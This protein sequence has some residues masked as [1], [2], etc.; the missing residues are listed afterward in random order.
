MT[1]TE[2]NAVA[3]VLRLATGRLAESDTA[4]RIR[5]DVA[6]LEQRAAKALN[7]TQLIDPHDLDAAIEHATKATTS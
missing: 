2:A 4:D 3:R 7:L 6:Y 1:I 5:V